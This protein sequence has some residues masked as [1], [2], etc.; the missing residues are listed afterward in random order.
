VQAAVAL[1]NALA[2]EEQTRRGALLKRELETLSRLIQVSRLLRPFQSLSSAD[3]DCQ[4]IQ[5]ATPFPGGA[6][7]RV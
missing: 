5:S 3:G 4:A 2:Y 6:D 1:N 7:Q